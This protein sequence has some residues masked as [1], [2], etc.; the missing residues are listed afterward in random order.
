MK[1][2]L[3]FLALLSALIFAGVR[4]GFAFPSGEASV[5]L[6]AFHAL[7]RI[8]DD[9]QGRG[10]G[11]GGR[12]GRDRGDGS[13]G[14]DRGDVGEGRDGGEERQRFR[15]DRG[16]FDKPKERRGIGAGFWG[17][18][19]WG[20]GPRWGHACEACRSSCE[21]GGEDSYCERCRIR[22]GW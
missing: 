7:T 11:R 5:S 15:F 20:Y 19:Y 2:C 12:E 13:E 4:A 21:D 18:P 1:R 14:R 17:G 8:D 3:C 22:C 10:E 16:D 6:L 9:R